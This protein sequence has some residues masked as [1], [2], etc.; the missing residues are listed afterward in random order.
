MGEQVPWN[1]SP[2]VFPSSVT[3]TT[4]PPRVVSEAG[5]LRLGAP[6]QLPPTTTPP[7]PSLSRSLGHPRAVLGDPAILHEPLKIPSSAVVAVLHV[8]ARS[9]PPYFNDFVPD[10]GIFSV[11]LP[12]LHDPY[13]CDPARQFVLDGRG[14]TMLGGPAAAVTLAKVALGAVS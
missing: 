7:P 3:Q 10:F 13:E 5:M 2:G 9:S 12:L 11:L 14:A 6:P 1:F 8:G 4:W